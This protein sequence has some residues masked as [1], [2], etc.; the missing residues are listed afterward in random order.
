MGDNIADTEKME[1]S[2][3]SEKIDM[4]LDE[5]IEL[6]KKEQKATSGIQR[7]KYKRMANRN[8]VLRK[9]GREGQQHFPF[10][11]GAYQ[12]QQGL[13]RPRFIGPYRQGFYRKRPN[14]F[15]KAA[16]GTNGVSPLNRKPWSS[17]GTGPVGHPRLKT[18]PWFSRMFYQ[19][20]RRPPGPM[21]RN[22]Q[23]HEGGH[24]QH[25][26]QRQGQE[27]TRPFTLNRGFLTQMKMNENFGKYQKVRS[28]RKAPSSGSILTVSV[29][30][31]M[32]AP[33]PQ[34]NVKQS[35]VTDRSPETGAVPL[36]QPKGIPLRFNFKAVA[37]QT[38]VSLN[39]RFTGL[40]IRGGTGHR[41]W[42]GRGRGR[43]VFLQ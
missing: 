13:Y 31:T 15:R 33:D 2:R 8:S 26:Q 32:A 16:P 3:S 1:V 27:K 6:N 39:D 9:L 10:K 35:T 4:T 29:P 28:W 7:T 34:A 40:K 20:Y 24:F 11:R 30:N 42:R 43:T 22:P 17:K 37:N 25:T 38:G 41:P 18:Q 21:R 14:N 19:P 12:F 23:L 36:V 5:I